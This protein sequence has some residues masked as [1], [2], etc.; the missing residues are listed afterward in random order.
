MITSS[1]PENSSE[2]DLSRLAQMVM[3]L[4]D[5]WNLSSE[6]QAFLLGLA[7]RNRDALGRY[8]EGARVGTT[9]EEY[10]RVGQLLGIHRSLRLLFP[11]N[12]DVAY[13]WMKMCNRAFGGMTPVDAIKEYGFAGLL[14]VRAYLDRVDPVRF[15]GEVNCS[16]RFVTTIV[17]CPV[18]LEQR[19]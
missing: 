9:R 2:A 17:S 7:P 14:M 15:V 11:R 5:H 4:F 12:R 6:D 1:I 10:E 19:R 3:S 16:L 13:G 8:R 18:F